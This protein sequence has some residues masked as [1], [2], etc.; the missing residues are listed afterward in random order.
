[1]PQMQGTSHIRRWDDHDKIWSFTLVVGHKEAT[2]PPPR[3]PV[4][5]VYM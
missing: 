3:I 1:M 5:T 4:S 2:L